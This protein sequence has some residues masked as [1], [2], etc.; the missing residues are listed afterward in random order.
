MEKKTKNI[1]SLPTDNLIWQMSVTAWIIPDHISCP[2]SPN[3]LHFSHNTISLHNIRHQTTTYHIIQTSHTLTCLLRTNYT[4]LHQTSPP[5]I[6]Y[7]LYHTTPCP[8]LPITLYL[9]TPP[10]SKQKEHL[11]K[12]THIL[13][14][15][16]LFQCLH[17]TFRWAKLPTALLLLIDF[18]LSHIYLQ[19][20][21]NIHLDPNLL[22]ICS[23]ENCFTPATKSNMPGDHTG[24]RLFYGR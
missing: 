23:I 20:H 5:G 24:T 22:C 17:I 16:L 1:L 8:R 4:T 2:S 12:N 14:V 18:Y 19:P 7:I 6:S 10:K 9:C 11:W 13:S 3:K 15:L 21:V